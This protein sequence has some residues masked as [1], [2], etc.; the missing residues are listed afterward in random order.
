M[1]RLKI[2]NPTKKIK[3][4]HLEVVSG[5]IEPPQVVERGDEPVQV[6]QLV[7]VQSGGTFFIGE[8]SIFNIQQNERLLMSNLSALRLFR[9][10]KLLSP[11]MVIL[12]I[13]GQIHARKLLLSTAKP[14]CCEI[15]RF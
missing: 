6:D 5:D 14:V 12:M 10:F 9:F 7:V 11:I 13:F 1:Q 4:C 3:F 15:L 2:Y 8:I